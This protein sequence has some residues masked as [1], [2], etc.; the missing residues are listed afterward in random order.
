MVGLYDTF[1]DTILFQKTK[2]TKLRLYK[3]LE[4]D[5]LQKRKLNRHKISRKHAP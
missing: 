3:A 2:M 4:G 5:G 1:N